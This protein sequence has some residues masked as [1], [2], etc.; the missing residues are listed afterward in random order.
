MVS[1]SGFDEDHYITRLLPSLRLMSN[2]E[3][4]IKS[5]ATTPLHHLALNFIFSDPIPSQERKSAL[6]GE[7]LEE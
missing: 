4:A 6:K 3:G 5:G 7:L 2:Q 1:V